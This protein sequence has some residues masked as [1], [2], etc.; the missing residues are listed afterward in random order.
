MSTLT[1]SADSEKVVVGGEISARGYLLFF[2]VTSQTVSAS[3][4]EAGLHFSSGK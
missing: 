1:P 3:C 2:F 4:T